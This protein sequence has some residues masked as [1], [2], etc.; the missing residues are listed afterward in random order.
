MQYITTW[1]LIV[2]LYTS[3]VFPLI[4]KTIKRMGFSHR[5]G[6]FILLTLLLCLIMATNG[7]TRE[8][9][10]IEKVPTAL[11][12]YEYGY[13][14]N[15][16]KN[17]DR[18]LHAI[19]KNICLLIPFQIIL[20]FSNSSVRMYANDY[21]NI[22][23]FI[24]AAW[25]GIMIMLMLSEKFQTNKMLTE[26]GKMSIV[27]FCTHFK[28]VDFLKVIWPKLLPGIAMG[29]V[30]NMLVFGSTVLL[31]MGIFEILERKNH[32]VKRRRFMT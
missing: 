9:I 13:L 5:V 16:Y 29:W 20:A 6:H 19:E 2:L 32:L 23:I 1:F 25:L 4:E 28:I 14:F 18:I 26:F 30:G 11:F 3:L 27:V 22:A 24:V 21:G 8:Y 10:S 31:E 15:S 7:R 12:F 17:K